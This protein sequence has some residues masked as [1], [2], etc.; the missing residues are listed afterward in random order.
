MA[1]L[2]KTIY[3]TSATTSVDSDLK[4][5]LYL[6]NNIL[7]LDV[8]SEFTRL[9]APGSNDKF[10]FDNYSIIRPYFKEIITYGESANSLS[11]SSTPI[12]V[13]VGTHKRI[14]S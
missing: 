4:N 11:V 13:E 8:S 1:D 2:V 9:V 5:N 6:Q 7:T 14:V 12:Y 3:T 10:S